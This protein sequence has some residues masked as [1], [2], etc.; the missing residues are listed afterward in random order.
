MFPKRQHLQSCTSYSTIISA[1][2]A[3]AILQSV[4]IFAATFPEKT[5]LIVPCGTPDVLEMAGWFRFLDLAMA[6]RVAAIW[7]GVIGVLRFLPALFLRGLHLKWYNEITFWRTDRRPSIVHSNP[8]WQIACWL[9][10]FALWDA[11]RIR[12]QF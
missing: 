1:P 6:A 5:R 8:G 11:L 7:A 3:S 10:C 9:F 2:T 4:S 12:T